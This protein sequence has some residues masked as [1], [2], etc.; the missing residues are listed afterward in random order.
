MHR[1]YHL[2]L[3]AK[4][5][6]SPNPMVGSVIVR[7]EH[8]LSEGWHRR[9]GDDHAEIAALKKL[10]GSAAGTRM[11]VTLEPCFHYGRTSPCVDRII[12]SGVNEVIIG[13]KD[14]NPK[15]NGKSI[16]KLK[17]AGIKIKVGLLQSELKEMNEVFIKYIKTKMPFVAAKCAQTLDGKI[18]AVNGRSQWITSQKARQFARGI[19]NEFD[20]ILV[21]VNTVLKDDPGLNPGK[22]SKKLIKIVLDSDL[23]ISP[24]ARLFSKTA[25]NQCIIATT[26]KAPQRK[27][28]A[29]RGQGARVMICRT[30]SGRIDMPWLFKE[31]ANMEITSVLLEGGAHIIGSALRAKLVDKMYFYI[32]PKI[33]GDQNALSSIVGLRVQNVNKAIKLKKVSIKKLGED[34]LV[35]GYV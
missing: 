34:V 10:K 26:D 20:A 6:T 19:R 30:R 33:F 23:K 14:P 27:I 24:N 17:R 8:I 21:G 13:M 22:K 35:T 1:A 4:G 25:P 12:Q 16:A 2:A 15:T 3:K 28:M 18:A 9:C 31:L 29:L 5:Q 7:G 11:F 32:A